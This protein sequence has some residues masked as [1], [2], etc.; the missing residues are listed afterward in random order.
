MTAN[1]MMD[2][3][4]LKKRRSEKE[5]NV[6]L[7]QV[8]DSKEEVELEPLHHATSV[9]DYFRPVYYEFTDHTVQ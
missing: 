4:K 2:A 5:F 9:E 3:V 6:L 8:N 1:G 7:A